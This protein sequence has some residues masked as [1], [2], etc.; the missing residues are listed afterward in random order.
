MW[1]MAVYAV[2]DGPSFLVRGKLCHE[3]R[4]AA[5]VENR[6][7]NAIFVAVWTACNAVGGCWRDLE[8]GYN[9]IN[10]IGWLT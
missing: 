2:I 4:F 5:L 1:F 6:W 8:N 3:W 9:C 10:I 7:K